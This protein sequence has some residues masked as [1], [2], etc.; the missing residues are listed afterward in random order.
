MNVEPVR[1]G[2][3]PAQKR[4]AKGTR[5]NPEGLSA[6]RRAFFALLAIGFRLKA[7][8]DVPPLLRPR[9]AP[10]RSL[11]RYIGNWGGSAG[12][13]AVLLAWL[14]DHSL[15]LVGPLGSSSDLDAAAGKINGFAGLLIKKLADAYSFIRSSI[16]LIFSP[17]AAAAAAQPGPRPVLHTPDRRECAGG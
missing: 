6:R 9:F 1:G 11:R 12:G 14:P 3:L 13:R 2:G 17:L 7:S 15:C 4:A 8:R 5:R 10:Q 16:R